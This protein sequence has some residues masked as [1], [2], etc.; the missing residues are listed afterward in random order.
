MLSSEPVVEDRKRLVVV[1]DDDL[2]RESLVQNLSDSGF[3]VVGYR[4]GRSALVS[5]EGATLPPDLILLDWKMP[6][7]SGIEVL[8]RLRNSEATSPVIFLTALSDQIYEEA[9]L[10]GGAVDFVEKSR[11]YAILLKRIELTLDGPRGKSEGAEDEPEPKVLKVGHLELNGEASRAF[12]KNERV[13]LSLPEFTIVSC[14]VEHAGRDVRYRALYDL[15]RGRGFVAGAGP[16]GYR[17][18]VRTFIKRIRQKFREVDD[19]F[20]EI[21]NYPGFGYRWRGDDGRTG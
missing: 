7:M 5:L 15:V 4:D 10:I 13:E 2:F 9:A 3:D 17:A 12:W 6:E 21:E 18:N 1:D 14:L 16:D 19:R 20:D 8:K 11:S